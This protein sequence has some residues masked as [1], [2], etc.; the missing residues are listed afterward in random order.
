MSWRKRFLLWFGPSTLGG[1]TFGDW[2]A[3][4]RD[5]RFTVDPS[6]WLRATSIT[7]CS[8]PQ[9]PRSRALCSSPSGFTGGLSE[10]CL[11]RV[12]SGDES[13][14]SERVGTL[15]LGVGISRLNRSRFGDYLRL[16]TS[17]DDRHDLEAIRREIV[18]IAP[19]FSDEP[20]ARLGEGMDSFAVLRRRWVRIS[21]CQA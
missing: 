18:R 21:F 16:M 20:I 19:E 6:Y 1:V 8:L 17:E 15:L 2:L 7:L 12:G 10:E 4:L 9:L 5:N 13:T 11:S 14:T 3:M